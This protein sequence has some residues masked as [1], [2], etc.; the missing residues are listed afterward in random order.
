[1]T[2]KIKSAVVGVG[3][4]G[5]FHAQKYSQSKKSELLAVVDTRED[6]AKTCASKNK[7]TYLTDYKKLLELGIQ[8]ASIATDTIHHFEIAK[9]LLENG[10]DVLIE[11]PITTSI[12]QAKE[13]IEI[14]KKNNRIIQVGHIERFN[15]SFREME[16]YL[17]S[18]LFFEVRRLSTFT[19]R[20]KDI[21]VVLD[22]MIHDIDIIAHLVGKPLIK[23][24]AIGIPVIT[25]N[26]DI[27]N[28]RLTFEGGAV[29]NVTASRVS[30]KSER[31]LR[32]FQPNVYINLD[33]GNKK[34]K[35]YSKKDNFL[36]GIIPQIA[37]EEYNIEERDALND[38]IDSFLDCVTSRERPIVSGED[39][40]IALELVEKIRS[41]FAESFVRF[42]DPQMR[43]MLATSMLA[44]NTMVKNLM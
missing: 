15:P 40:L 23:V 28:A 37:T 13:L 12:A 2:E 4:L 35:M 7:T 1:M 18:P 24:D 30:L 6:V 19:G 14:A 5:N 3:Y 43:A 8:C 34:L 44:D 10:V 17:T 31:S 33:Y 20:G 29:A 32:I 38:Q 39:G 27:A 11:K 21:D 42:E 9:W 22:L 25:K 36:S 41:A 16:K 26:V